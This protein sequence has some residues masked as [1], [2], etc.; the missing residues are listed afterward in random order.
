MSCVSVVRKSRH[1][2][3]FW[4]GRCSYRMLKLTY[5]VVKMV[6]PLCLHELEDG[7]YFG[8]KVFAKDKNASDYVRDSWMPLVEDGREVW[9]V[10]G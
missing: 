4:F 9:F 5:E 7:C 8:S 3:V 6:C 1:A 2:V 10:K